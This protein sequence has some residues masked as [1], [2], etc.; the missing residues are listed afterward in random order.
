MQR[1]NNSP[2]SVGGADSKVTALRH[3]SRRSLIRLVLQSMLAGTAAVCLARAA[4]TTDSLIESI[5]NVRQDTG[6]AAIGLTLVDADN[7]RWSGAWGVAD[8]ATGLRVQPDTMFRIGSVTKS[9]TA[10]AVL[11]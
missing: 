5:E 9:F 1:P 3:N 6:I 4:A 7:I 8:R 2:H 10:L 11:R